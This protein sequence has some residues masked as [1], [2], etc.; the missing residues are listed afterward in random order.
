MRTAC[1]F[2]GQKKNHDGTRITNPIRVFPSFKKFYF[3]PET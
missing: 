2:I 3:V 1:L